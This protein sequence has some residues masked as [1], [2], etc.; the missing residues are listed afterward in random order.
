MKRI[1]AITLILLTTS[2]TSLPVDFT[3]KTDVKLVLLDLSVKDS[4]N[5]PVS[6][7]TKEDFT[8]LENGHR[9]NIKFFANKD[10]PVSAG[11]VVD[12]SASMAAKR[13]EVLSAAE[14]FV[15]E[16]NPLDEMFVLNFNDRVTP[17]LPQGI[18]FSSSIK[19][20]HD[21]LF[22]GRPMGRTAL[23]D[24]I[25]AGLTQLK[26]AKRD[27]HA[28]LLIS[29]GL[30]NA[31]QTT[32][33]DLLR[34]VEANVVTIYTIGLYEPGSPDRD[35]GLLKRLAHMSGGDA[36]FPKSPDEMAAICHTIASDVRSRYTIGYTP[37]FD[38]KPLRQ[39]KV[40]VKDA[41]NRKLTAKTRTNYRFEEAK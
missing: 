16:S 11:L 40:H 17:G 25:A 20:L 29:D 35:P 30:D 36:Y 9:Q 21:A 38:E 1:L 39:I 19:A 41:T 27:R 34:L 31:S 6:G 10:T 12:A 32:R 24:A 28:L 37:Q 13:H 22:R 8:I 4:R 15:K 23:N 2:G 5:S 3:L 33:Q 7:L 18:S 26:T 14:L